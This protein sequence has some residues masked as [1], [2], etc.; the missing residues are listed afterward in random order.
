MK[1]L[2][3]AGNHHSDRKGTDEA[4]WYD[5]QCSYGFSLVARN[6]GVVNGEGDQGNAK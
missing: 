6:E 5:V 3:K 1:L 2:E 4:N